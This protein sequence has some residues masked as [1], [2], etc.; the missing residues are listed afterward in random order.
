MRIYLRFDK[1]RAIIELNTLER[2]NDE[3][4]SCL[5]D[6]NMWTYAGVGVSA[7]FAAI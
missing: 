6:I 7:I 1:V 3:V 2:F 5:F 4:F